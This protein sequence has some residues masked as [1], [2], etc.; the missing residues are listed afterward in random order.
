[1]HCR[2]NFC[3]ACARRSFSFYCHASRGSDC[4]VA[5]IILMNP[6]FWIDAFFEWVRHRARPLS[7][8]W[9]LNRL[10][11]ETIGH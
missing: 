3:A 8:H 1:M 2:A 6:S 4:R 11:T 9:V 5:R 7:L 10:Y